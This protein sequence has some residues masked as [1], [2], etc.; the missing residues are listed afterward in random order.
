MVDGSVLIKRFTI[1]LYTHLK[2][3]IHALSFP[4]S[5]PLFLSP[6]LYFTLRGGSDC[7]PTR[8]KVS[9]IIDSTLDTF[10]TFGVMDCGHMRAGGSKVSSVLS[11]ITLTCGATIR[12]SSE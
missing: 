11:I 9:V 2:F 3:L 7:S 10:S 6:L 1:I 4:Q 5:L 8:N 12:P